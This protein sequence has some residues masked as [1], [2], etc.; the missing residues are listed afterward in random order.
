MTNRALKRR[1]INAL[2]ED[3]TILVSSADLS[4]SSGFKLDH[5]QYLGLRESDLKRL[6][7]FGMARRGY[8]KNEWRVGETLPNGNTVPEGLKYRGTGSTVKW[9]LVDGDEI[10][11]LVKNV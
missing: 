1:L 2:N 6:E 11:S 3:N 10:Q 7:S 4:K 5:F 9:I 8:S